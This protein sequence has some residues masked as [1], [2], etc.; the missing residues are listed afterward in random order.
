[1]S[2]FSSSSSTHHQKSQDFGLAIQH[3]KLCVVDE[4]IVFMGGFDLC[5]GR[6]DT[7]QHSLVD[8]RPEGFESIE[9]AFT[10]GLKRGVDDYQVWPGKGEP[11]TELHFDTRLPATSGL[12]YS[13]QRVSD[14]FLL[15]R[16]QDDMYD[17]TMT[18]RQPW[19]DFGVQLVGQPA[20]DMARH[21]IQR[22]VFMGVVFAT[23][24]RNILQ[25][26]SPASHQTSLEIDAIPRAARGF[27]C[28]RS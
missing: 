16:P 11:V 22:S 23:R 15:N 19:H 13:N 17:R 2:V 25:L 27:D 24:L 18:P 20:R 26:E 6:W 12:D 5:F 8:D 9:S 10:Q 7:P 3:E 21:F 1:M 14:F 4:T 28:S